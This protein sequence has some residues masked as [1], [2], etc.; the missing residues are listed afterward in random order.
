MDFSVI[1]AR[2]FSRLIWLIRSQPHSVD[3]Q[4]G[5]LRAAVTVAR[6]GEVTIRSEGGRLTANGTP[7]PDI[8]TGVADVAAALSGAVTYALVFARGAPPADVLGVARLI[9][10]DSPDPLVRRMAQ[11]APKSVRME[12]VGESAAPARS[13][14]TAQLTSEIIAEIEADKA[15]AATA[16]AAAAPVPAPAAPT[17]GIT[18]DET[19]DKL[20]GRLDAV[21]DP[22]NL[23]TLLDELAGRIDVAAREGRIPIV[24]RGISA[25][26]EREKRTT[27]ADLRRV[28]LVAVRRVFRP[29]VMRVVMPA[30]HQP[31]DRERLTAV[32]AHAAE[33]GA[34]VVFEELQRASSVE[35]R[36]GLVKLLRQLP[37]AV[38][39]LVKLLNDQPWYVVRA[40]VDLLG[41]IG[42]PD[43]ER[44]IAEV[45]RHN[46]D[47]VRRA[48]AGALARYDTQFAVDALYRALNDASVQV[49][50]QAVA[51]LS[52]RKGNARAA[53]II[54]GAIDEEPEVEV[55]LAEIAA[56]GRFATS[57]AV[58]KLTRAAEPDGR[59]FRRK[60]PAYRVAAVQALAE[61]RTPLAMT[62]IQALVND[63]EREVREAA[64]RA[65][66]TARPSTAAAA[67]AAS[68]GY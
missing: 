56:L 46:D 6:D 8:L 3:E 11:L 5:A 60:N 23:N 53:S 42:P 49:R 64:G 30:L 34:N 65:L 2:H 1:F 59:L 12:P 4:K 28:Y 63:R 67:A 39:A 32:L 48:A 44:A 66:A 41:E 17:S 13:R 33:D 19:L 31:G 47:R 40:A 35:E 7:L 51:G 20:F 61:A 27:D 57:D 38:P 54:V 15:R 62:A 50:L 68:A 21:I 55:Q 36:D 43:A 26:M 29:Q 16:D 14:E 37:A 24:L 9:G 45:L 58:S 18:G 10:S 22:K 25:L 52:A